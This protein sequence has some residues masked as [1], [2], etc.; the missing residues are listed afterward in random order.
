MGTAIPLSMTPLMS[1]GRY[2]LFTQG[3]PRHLQVRCEAKGSTSAFWFDVTDCAV[4]VT[5]RIYDADTGGRGSFIEFT[6]PITEEHETDIVWDSE[7]SKKES[8]QILERLAGHGLTVFNETLERGITTRTLF[9]KYLLMARPGP[10]I[11]IHTQSGWSSDCR[12]FVLGKSVYPEQDQL[13]MVEDRDSFISKEQPDIDAWKSLTPHIKL[14]PMWQFAAQMAFSGPLIKILKIPQAS[15]GGFV[16]HGGS[17]KGKTYANIIGRAV[18]GNTPISFSATRT[19]LEDVAA[20][21]NDRTLFLDELHQ[22]G[23]LGRSESSGS[24]QIGQVI[25]DLANGTGKIRRVDAKKL[26]KPKHWQLLWL[27]TGEI[28]SADFIRPALG[29]SKEGQRIRAADIPADHPWIHVDLGVGGG[30]EICRQIEDLG[31]KCGGAAGKLFIEALARYSPA[32]IKELR[33]DFEKLYKK[34]FEEEAKTGTQ[35][36]LAERCALVAMAGKVAQDMGLLPNGVGYISAPLNVFKTWQ[37]NVG[38][39]AAN[40]IQRCAQHII[41]WIDEHRGD[42][43]IP[44]ETIERAGFDKLGAEPR[45]NYRN[46]AGFIKGDWCYITPKIFRSLCATYGGAP[47]VCRVF[48]QEKILDINAGGNSNQFQLPEVREIK[49]RLIETDKTET[50]TLGKIVWRG[51]SKCYALDLAQLES[52]AAPEE[53]KK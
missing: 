47:G 21:H 25:Y 32:K 16:L 6:H 50:I 31:P 5:A 2:Q 52:F 1:S 13:S 42:R 51:R 29:E 53:I 33:E 30:R 44:I 43:L 22:A 48:K 9:L 38:G 49:T 35:T 36:R 8:G 18:F 10:I 19:G 24:A 39:E 41:G 26:E 7:L 45:G 11:S 28:S 27:G 46:F 4:E 23:S 15:L 12:H 17:G 20:V 37:Q 34:Y 40:D 3:E 14:Q